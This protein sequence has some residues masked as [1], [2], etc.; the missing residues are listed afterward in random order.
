MNIKTPKI[1]RDQIGKIIQHH[2]KYYADK[3]LKVNNNVVCIGI[4]G[5]FLDSVGL[6]NRNDY[7]VWDD[8]IGWH[9]PRD[10]SAFAGNTDPSFVKSSA[11]R[12]LA[13]LNLGVYTFIPG[14]HKK[15]AK[16]FRAYPEGTSLPCTRNGKPSTCSYIDIH[17]GGVGTWSEGCQTLPPPNWTKFQPEVYA[18]LAFYK[19]KLFNYILIENREIDGKQ[20]FYDADN[21]LIEL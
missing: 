2:L 3:F 13:K 6:A 21:R 7:N 12:E 17:P 19:Q 1:T 10:N 15:V 9:S 18:E 20:N 16:A 8:V 4:R 5:Y 11:G 14:H